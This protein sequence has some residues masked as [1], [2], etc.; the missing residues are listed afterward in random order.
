M[1]RFGSGAD[2]ARELGISRVAVHKAEKS[3]RIS[4]TAEGKFDLEAAA[5][6]YRLHTNAAQQRRALAQQG[7]GAAVAIPD[8]L[9]SN[10]WR[11]RRDRAEAERAEIE[12]ARLKGVV[13]DCSDLSASGQRIG[14]AFGSGLDQIVDRT[15]AE[16]GENDAQ[17]RHI[18]NV[19]QREFDRLRSEIADLIEREIQ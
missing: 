14:Y 17:R 19:L 11:I 18:R 16:C 1:P 15:A 4:R 5:I 3:G 10:D 6:Q 7:N 13:A 8:P 9:S 12:T 2:L